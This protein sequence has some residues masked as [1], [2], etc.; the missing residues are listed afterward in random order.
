MNYFG[1]L[2]ALALAAF[3]LTMSGCT[4]QE[5]TLAGV[6]IGAT[7]GGIIGGAAGGPGGA[8]GGA[9]AGGVLGGVIGHNIK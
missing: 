8:V 1:Y 6:G 3:A 7:S 9:V 2:A 4:K 5:K